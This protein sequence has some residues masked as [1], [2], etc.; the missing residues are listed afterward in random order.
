MHLHHQSLR[1]LKPVRKEILILIGTFVSR[2]EDLDTV[3]H[4]LAPPL[5]D[6][7]LDDYRAGAPQAREAEVLR[8]LDIFLTKLEVRMHRYQIKL[9]LTMRPFCRVQWR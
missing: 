3:R 2:A 5:L 8:V 4:R 7:I 9:R 6:I 1:D